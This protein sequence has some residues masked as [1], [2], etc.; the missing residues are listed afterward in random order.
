M[1]DRV[2]ICPQCGE[3]G[4]DQIVPCHSSLDGFGCVA[5][6]LCHRCGFFRLATFDWGL[7]HRFLRRNLRFV[8]SRRTMSDARNWKP[9]DDYL[10][11]GNTQQW[12]LRLQVSDSWPRIFPSLS[13]WWKS[14]EFAEPSDFQVFRH[15]MQETSGNLLAPA[16]TVRDFLSLAHKLGYDDCF[17]QPLAS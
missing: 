13:Q 7:S 12:A 15:L 10:T 9:I 2:D 17:G 14:D 4:E 6:I 1:F 5:G 11:L 3:V 16:Y 8:R